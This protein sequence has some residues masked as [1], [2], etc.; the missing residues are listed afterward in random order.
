MVKPVG[1]GS[2]LNGF[3][4]THSLVLLTWAAPK[5]VCALVPE[6]RSNSDRA[7]LGPNPSVVGLD[8]VEDLVEWTFDPKRVVPIVIYSVDQRILPEEYS[9]RTKTAARRL[10]G[11]ADIRMLTTDSEPAFNE[12]MDPMSLSVYQGA[13][14]VYL[15]G[16]DR[17]DPQPWR[18]R[19][20]RARHLS[21]HPNS[22]ANV[23]VRQILPRMASQRPPEIYRLRIKNLLDLQRHGWEQIAEETDADLNRVSEELCGVQREKEMFQLEREIAIDEAV[24]S[25]REAA[26]VLRRLQALRNYVREVGGSPEEIECQVEDE[27]ESASCAEAIE[28]AGSLENIV[29]HPNAPHDVSRLDES[30]GSDLWAQ[31]IFRHLQALDRYAAGKADGFNGSFKEWCERSGSDYALASKFVAM[32]ESEWVQNNERARSRRVLPVDRRVD[33]SGEIEMF[34]HLKTV[35]GGGTT[36]PRIYFHDDTMRTTKKIHIGF[37]GPHDLMPNKSTN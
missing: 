27:L 7:R 22:A 37:I 17:D 6:R 15:P 36:I 21:V 28:M 18:H 33:P 9:A 34:S 1:S 12:T 10:A 25:E 23:V 29:I 13:V 5:L 26:R 30:S 3:P 2:T 14:R 31:R 11:C 16:I 4:T 20:T 19:F 35:Q 8:N 32:S 24:D